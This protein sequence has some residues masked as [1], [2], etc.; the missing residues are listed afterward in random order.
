DERPNLINLDPLAPQAA[1]RA[2]LVLRGALSNVHQ[3]LGHSVDAHIRQPGRGPHGHSLAEHS[4]DLGA[5]GGG[6]LVHDGHCSLP[7]ES[8]KHFV[9]LT[10]Q[11]SLV[12]KTASEIES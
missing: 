8:V 12:T 7:R 1:K 2:V 9:Q 11:A 6:K 4:E 3:Q 5:F 10:R